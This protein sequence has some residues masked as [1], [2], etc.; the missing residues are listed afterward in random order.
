MKIKARI[1]IIELREEPVL[2]TEVEVPSIEAEVARIIRHL[3]SKRKYKIQVT[4]E[5]PGLD[6]ERCAFVFDGSFFDKIVRPKEDGKDMPTLPEVILNMISE[7]IQ[8]GDL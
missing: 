8:M 4:P 7:K 2:T 3:N 1:K 5:L 6:P